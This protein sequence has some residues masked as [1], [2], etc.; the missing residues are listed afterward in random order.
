MAATPDIVPVPHSSSG[1][2]RDNTGTVPDT[3]THRLEEP[4][5]VGGPA[6]RTVVA[7]T[8]PAAQPVAQH[9]G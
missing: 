1:A 2:D 8:A 4:V 3:G 7:H 9:L 5:A 6:V